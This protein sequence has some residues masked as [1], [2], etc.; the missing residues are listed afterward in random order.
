VGTSGAGGICYAYQR[1]IAARGEPYYGADGSVNELAA[2]A[3]GV[4]LPGSACLAKQ[5]QWA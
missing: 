3:A 5:R 2:A 4:Y 1:H